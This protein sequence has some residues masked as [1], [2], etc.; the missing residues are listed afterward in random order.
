MNFRSRQRIFASERG[1]TLLVALCFT[2]V[3]ALALASYQSVCY[4]TLITG[5]RNMQSMRS[6]QLAEA[7][8]EE[9]LWTLNNSYPSNSGLW[10]TNGWTLSN[11]DATKTLSGFTYESAAVTGQ[12]SITVHG[13]LT[14]ATTNLQT[15]SDPPYIKAKGVTQA[16][17]GTTVSRTLKASF[18]ASTTSTSAMAPLFP[19][20][21]AAVGTNQSVNFTG[22]ATVDS[23]DSSLGAYPGSNSAKNYSAV[24]SGSSVVLPSGAQIKGYVATAPTGSNAVSLSN[25]SSA[26]LTGPTTSSGVKI[27]SSRETTSPY[28]PAFD[29]PT[30]SGVG[31]NLTEPSTTVHLGTPGAT[32][33]TTYYA[34]LGGTPGWAGWYYLSSGTLEVDGPVIL[35]IPGSLYINGSGSIVIS[36][37][38]GSNASL[39]IPISG[40]AYIYSNGGIDN[41]TH[42]PSNLAIIGTATSTGNAVGLWTST[43]FYGAIYTPNSDI[44]VWGASSSSEIFGSLVGNSITVYPYGSPSVPIHYDMNLTNSVLSSVTTPFAVSN[45]T[46]SSP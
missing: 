31:T 42:I 16:A 7:G 14:V 26:L 41:Q 22:N 17:D 39:Q 5:A 2:L 4:Y 40:S 21:I 33:P 6:R 43:K 1:S 28:Q 10:T 46:D 12:V 25:G 3:L 37:T 44:T 30:P 18:G 11:G 15:T 13:Y 34:T 36:S 32:V 8:L 19:N 45:I 23:Y 38:A 29:V 24:V 35:V 20:A 27:D 9:A